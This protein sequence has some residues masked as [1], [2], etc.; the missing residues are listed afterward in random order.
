M[1]ATAWWRPAA[2][3]G[4]MALF[5]AATLVSVVAPAG[6][7]ASVLAST[8]PYSRGVLYTASALGTALVAFGALS[9]LAERYV[10][11]LPIELLRNAGAMTLTLYVAHALV[12]NLIVDWL[13]WVR[14]TGLDTALVFVRRVLGRRHRRRRLVAPPLRHRSGRARLPLPRRLTPPEIVLT[15]FRGHR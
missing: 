8:D 13:G 7:L 11:S 1:L 5:G 3:G 6:P 12:F 15:R 9:W 10:D 4:G 14:P 2:I